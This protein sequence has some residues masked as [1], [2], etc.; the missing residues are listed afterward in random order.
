MTTLKT[1]FPPLPLYLELGGA[2]APRVGAGVDFTG[3]GGGVGG[4]AG[5]GRVVRGRLR[6]H[7]LRIV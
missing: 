6:R 5:E 7:L 2:A 3:D 1:S 4:R